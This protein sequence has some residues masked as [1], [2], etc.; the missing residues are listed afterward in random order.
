MM[1]K[2]YG[3]IAISQASISDMPTLIQ[4][5]QSTASSASDNV[6]MSVS[7]GIFGGDAYGYLL[8][9]PNYQSSMQSQLTDNFLSLYTSL[10]KSNNK[11]ISS[12]DLFS[13]FYVLKIPDYGSQS[14]SPAMFDF[15]PYVY[16]NGIKIS[17]NHIGM[18]RSYVD[19]SAYI[20]IDRAYN[21]NANAQY[22]AKIDDADSSAS[23]TYVTDHKNQRS[24]STSDYSAPRFE[25]SYDSTSKAF[26][27]S[28]STDY[29]WPGFDSLSTSDYDVIAVDSIGGYERVLNASS[30]SLTLI[31]S[32]SANEFIS[33]TAIG[34]NDANLVSK[35]STYFK[36]LKTSDTKSDPAKS[37]VYASL[38]GIS[39]SYKIFLCPRS[40]QLE[41][42]SL[43]EKFS[44]ISVFKFHMMSD[45]VIYYKG[46]KLIPGIDYS[47]SINSTGIVASVAFNS[48][49]NA[50]GCALSSQYCEVL[51][52][53]NRM[54]YF[55]I[56]TQKTSFNVNGYLLRKHIY[57]HNLKLANEFVEI[58]NGGSLTSSK[59]VDGMKSSSGDL[60]NEICIEDYNTPDVPSVSD[61]TYL[62]PGSATSSDDVNIIDN[63]S[64]I[65][66]PTNSPISYCDVM[67][68]CDTASSISKTH[69]VIAYDLAYD[70]YVGQ[71]VID[72]E[73]SVSTSGSEY[74]LQGNLNNSLDSIASS[75]ST[76]IS[77]YMA[78][79]SSSSAQAIENNI[80]TIKSNLKKMADNQP[81]MTIKASGSGR[82]PILSGTFM[83]VYMEMSTSS[84]FDVYV[85]GSSTASS[86]ASLIDCE[87]GIVPEKDSSNKYY[88]VHLP[89]YYHG[90]SF[91]YSSNVSIS[92]SSSANSVTGYQVML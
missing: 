65:Y 14:R 67:S 59:D 12:S 89:F 92:I 73:I 15:V 23:F 21:R 66:S 10:I 27:G 83:A 20:L 77:N 53:M 29:S 76:A 90:G 87:Y 52:R 45:F 85:Y 7:N 62:N 34:S 24:Q 54:R 5:Y 1:I 42:S 9:F 41:S 70:S 61:S 3:P 26:I 43:I 8:Q 86:A 69:D 11:A 51:P 44:D 28:I 22:E 18:L 4:L 79:L 71:A 82:L 81:A 19:K 36:L 55:D 40:K 58:F 50:S 37:V 57:K 35:Q 88:Y 46:K 2:K 68:A 64:G 25:L 74:V 84:P 32:S 47:A 72:G 31:D 78:Y 49:T 48:T 80:H 33:Q 39:S 16:Y 6:T 38:T 60:Y 75:V 91:K 63:Y 13:Q 17:Q 30:Y 56:A